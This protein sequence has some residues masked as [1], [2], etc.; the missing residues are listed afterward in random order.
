[1]IFEIR[2][3]NPYGGVQIVQKPLLSG[4]SQH[5]FL[6]LLFCIKNEKKQR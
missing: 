5:C 6:I 1:M 2:V 4:C 3:R